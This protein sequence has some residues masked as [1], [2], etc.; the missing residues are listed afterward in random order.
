MAA[1]VDEG[2]IRILA[3]WFQYEEPATVKLLLQVVG[4][5]AKHGNMVRG[6]A[7]GGRYALKRSCHPGKQLK[8]PEVQCV[9]TDGVDHTLG[10]GPREPS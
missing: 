10:I 2:A 4:I 6:G 3:D 7:G 5:F 8:S 1:V 9:I